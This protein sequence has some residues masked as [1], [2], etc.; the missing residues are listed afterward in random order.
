MLTNIQRW[1]IHINRVNCVS[2]AN[3]LETKNKISFV[4]L[5]WFIDTPYPGKQQNQSDKVYH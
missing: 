2:P 4:L 5:L 1:S 3:I